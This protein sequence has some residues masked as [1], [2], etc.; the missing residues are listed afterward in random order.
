[1]IQVKFLKKKTMRYLLFILVAENSVNSQIDS[2]NPTTSSNEY[3][4]A[5]QS[6]DE[7]NTQ[8][9]RIIFSHDVHL[10]QKHQYSTNTYKLTGESYGTKKNNGTSCIQGVKTKEEMENRVQVL[11]HLQVSVFVKNFTM[12]LVESIF[13]SSC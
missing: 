2:Q 11:P 8:T 4:I 10:E 9:S 13:F 7:N 6:I 3:Q 1:M 5:T 12:N